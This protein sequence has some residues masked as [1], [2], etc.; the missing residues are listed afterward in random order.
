ML[1]S[2]IVAATSRHDATKRIIGLRRS[3]KKQ[4]IFLPEFKLRR[5]ECEQAQSFYCGGIRFEVENHGPVGERQRTT[6][7]NSV[8]RM[9][10]SVT[11][12][13]YSA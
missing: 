12:R 11:N 2:H 4:T 1:A 6:K 8:R 13:E 5:G 9:I 7:V 10:L 3:P